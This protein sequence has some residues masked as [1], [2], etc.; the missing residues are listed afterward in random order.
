MNC[1]LAQR[2]PTE[3][4][5]LIVCDLET[6]TMRRPRTDFGCC[7][8]EENTHYSLSFHRYTV[9]SV[10]HQQCQQINN[11]LNKQLIS[12]RNSLCC[13]A[14]MILTSATWRKGRFLSMKIGETFQCFVQYNNSGKYCFH[15]QQLVQDER[16][17]SIHEWS[18]ID[19]RN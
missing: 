5:C 12:S 3:R 10:R 15:S 9:L 1:S 16:S 8:T 7:A 6:S 4:V 17:F 19:F 18:C 2:N 14:G 11:Q 13:M